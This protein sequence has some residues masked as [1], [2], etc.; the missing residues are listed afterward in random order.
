M[1]RAV[2]Y[3]ARTAPAQVVGGFR[4]SLG[5]LTAHA[6]PPPPC[7]EV[8]TPRT[9][10]GAEQQEEFLSEWCRTPS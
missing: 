1:K 10:M 6:A 8:C 2:A 3:V 7:G 4:T 9:A 5:E